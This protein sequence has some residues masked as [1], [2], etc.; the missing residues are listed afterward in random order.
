MMV[1]KKFLVSF[2]ECKSVNFSYIMFSE[3]GMDL[4]FCFEE[5]F[6]FLKYL[7]F[8]VE[9]FVIKLVKL[10][11]FYLVEIQFWKGGGV[12][13]RVQFGLL[14]MGGRDFIY[15]CDI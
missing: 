7:Q 4:G 3:E 15:I 11:N 10:D 13:Y 1:G 6:M 9:E 5:G 8:Y 14:K 2:N 12:I